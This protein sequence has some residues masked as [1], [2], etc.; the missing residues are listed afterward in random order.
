M[1]SARVVV[2]GG[3]NMGASVLYHLA[4]EGWTD[5]VLVEK[6]ELTSG[7]TWHAAGLV[8]RMTAGHA[9]GICH[10]YAVDLYKTIEDET[11]QGVSWH[12]CGSLRVA[13]TEDHRAWLMH[14]RDAVLA[15]GQE[16]RWV[17]PE[18]IAKLN[19]IYDTSHIIGGTY[20]PDDGHVD[21]SGTCQAMAKGA[22]M[23]GAKVLRR[24]RVTDVQ[25]M[26]S[27]EWKVVTEQGDIIC[28]HV[29]NAGGYHARQIGAFSGLDLPIVPMQHHYVVT[30]AVPEFE[31]MGHEIPVTRDDYFTGYLRREQGGALIGLYDTHDAL[32]KWREG[33]PWDSENE[34]FEPDYDRIM[35]WLEKCFER[36]PCLMERGI[37][38][39]VNG[40]ITYTP[41]GHPLVGPA[42]GLRNHWLACGATVGIAWGPGLG[43]ALAQWMVHGTADIS[44]RGFDPRRF[45][46]RVDE[47]Y[48]YQRCR[49]NYMTRLS[50]PYPQLQYE[51][52]REIR[53]S[54]V[55]DRTKALHAVFEEA[56]GWERPRV[57]GKPE[58]GG[59]EPE[60][61]KR[62]PSWEAALAE[63]RAVHEGVGIGDFS[64]FSKFEVTGPEAEAYLNRL[65]ANRMPKKVGGTCLTLLLNEQGTI[66]GEATI[67]RLAEDRFWFVTGGPSE[68]R[69]WDWITVHQRGSEDV[70]IRNLSDDW[71][72]L[73]VAGPKAREVLAPLSDASL[74]NADFG[75]LKAREMSVAGVNLIALRLSFS[76]ELAWEL[77]APMDQLGTVWDAIWDAGQPHGMVPFGSKALEMMRMEKAYRGGHELANDAS[78]VHTDQM[79]FVKFD[80]TFVGKEALAKLAE[81]GSSSVIAYLDIQMEGTDVLGGEAVYLNGEKVGSISSGGFGPVTGR[82]L[83]FAFVKPQVAKPGTELEVIVFGEMHKAKV[84]PDA[85][86]DPQNLRLRDVAATLEVAL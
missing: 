8:S 21:P 1:E 33:C 72:I 18:E 31:A 40:A 65:C 51:T 12:N 37:K 48:I 49:E 45:H 26:P 46:S 60:S 35:P 58:W 13:A 68:R 41:D 15:R 42:P 7:A 4:K 56:G 64:A 29:V 74:E 52:C 47:D 20:T 71:G 81:T 54:G 10:D 75:W 70:S 50:L 76:G 86:L 3:G 2:I 85:V 9:L 59:K 44:M 83:A 11:E 79:R 16:C 82:N 69:V 73:T 23:R 39:I 5:V 61:W 17:T 6:A 67:A 84:L 30:D 32:A 14:T 80:K 43:R 55:H 25:Q 77:H 63:A 53:N 62:G 38:R 78:P 57:Y 34:L 66:E 36:Y 24:N 28:E 27:G 19:P 22:R